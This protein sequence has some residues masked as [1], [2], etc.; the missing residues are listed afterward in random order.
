LKASISEIHREIERK[1]IRK[2]STGPHARPDTKPKR[3]KRHL[4]PAK[5]KAPARSS[6]EVAILSILSRSPTS[7]ITTAA[8]LREVKSKWFTQLNAEDLRAVYPESKKKVV[9]TVVKFA[10]K[11]LVEK[12]QIYAPDE[13]NPVGTWRATSLGLERVFKEREGWQPR[14]VEV[15]SLVEGEE[16]EE[17][18]GDGQEAKEADQV[19]TDPTH[20]V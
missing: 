10:R 5:T 9:D 12:G 14:Y 1:R 15:H 19:S 6:P 20:N 17:V 8:V 3:G 16:D 11:H 7:G 2:H 13:E 18:A 4:V